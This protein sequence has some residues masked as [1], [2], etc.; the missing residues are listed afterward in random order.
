MDDVVKSLLLR[1]AEELD[2]SVLPVLA[3]RLE[4][5]GDER[6]AEVRN[7]RPRLIAQ[8]LLGSGQAVVMGRDVRPETPT[9]RCRR[10][11]GLFPNG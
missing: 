11:L 9:E 6:A 7:P 3:D 1:L 4:E 2:A 5:L 8:R 10:V